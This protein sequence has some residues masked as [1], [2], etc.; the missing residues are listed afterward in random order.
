MHK[1][2]KNGRGAKVTTV[3]LTGG[4]VVN[5]KPEIEINSDGCEVSFEAYILMVLIMLCCS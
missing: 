4:V 5:T 2:D 1:D 3:S